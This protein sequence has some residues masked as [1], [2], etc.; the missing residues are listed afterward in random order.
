[1]LSKLL[2][3]AAGGALGSAIRYLCQKGLQAHFPAGTLLVN[4]AGCLLIGI[5]WGTW[6]K[7]NETIS[8]LLATGFCGG[9][10]TFSAFSQESIQML[11][12]EQWLKATLY[13]TISVVAGLLATFAGFKLSS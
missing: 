5:I 1:M 10:T 12:A 9:F 6:N 8:L 11:L 3:V 4:I 2:L 13:I 7:S